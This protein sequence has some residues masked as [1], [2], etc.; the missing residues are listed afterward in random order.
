MRLKECMCVYC[1]ASFGGTASG[2]G[3]SRQDASRLRIKRMLAR[4]SSPDTFLCDTPGGSVPISLSLAIINDKYIFK[5]TATLIIVTIKIQKFPSAGH[6]SGP[7]ILSRADNG[8][9][10]K[11][12]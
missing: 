2:D 8:N 10:I 11:T 4:D 6:T 5:T 1:L 3:S 12:M 9:I 7:S